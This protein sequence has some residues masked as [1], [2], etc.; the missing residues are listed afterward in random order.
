MERQELYR[1]IDRRVDNMLE[2]GLVAEV[3][4]LIARGYSFN[5]PSMSG[6]GYRQIGMYLE[7]KLA[8]AEAVQQIKFET[9][10]FVRHQYNWFRLKDARINWYNVTDESDAAI[11]DSIA[12]F[13]RSPGNKP[14]GAIQ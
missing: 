12:I 10:R 4:N 11:I 6:I 13:L 1:R 5:L 14:G 8:L 2:Q 7:G 9:H 3:E